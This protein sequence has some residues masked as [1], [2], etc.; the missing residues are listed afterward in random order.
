MVDIRFHDSG[1]PTPMPAIP[2]TVRLAFW[3]WMGAVAAAII[4][5]LVRFASEADGFVATVS[6]SYAEIGVRLSA[7]AILIIL[8]S[9]MRRGR[10]Y[11]R[12]L[13]MIIFG[14]LG[15]FSLTFEPVEW[16]ADGGQVST[17]LAGAD[18]ALWTVIV[19]RVAHILFVIAAIVLAYGRSARGY[20]SSERKGLHSRG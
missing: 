9:L 14:G 3:F 12:H 1:N 8:A 5:V 19:S 11:A 4:E 2:A 6:S 20:F 15:I 16:L 17:F 7:Y 18:A 13:L 10:N